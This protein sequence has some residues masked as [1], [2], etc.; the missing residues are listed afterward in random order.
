MGLATMAPG[1]TDEV[2]AA[3]KRPVPELGHAQASEGASSSVLHCDKNKVWLDPN[4]TSEIA[5]ANSCQQIGKLIQDGLIIRKPVTVRS[6][7]QCW[8]NTLDCRMGRHMG[9]GI[10][11]GHCTA[12]SDLDEE[13]ENSLPT[14]QRIAWI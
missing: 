1:G 14:A 11:K 7:A 9:I 8:K 3:L 12:G 13:D 2:E 6:Q 10:A 5:N 4:E